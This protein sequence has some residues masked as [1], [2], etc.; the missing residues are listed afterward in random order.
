MGFHS[1]FHQFKLLQKCPYHQI[2]LQRECPSCKTTIPF[3]ISDSYT[4]SPFKCRCGEHLLDQT[5]EKSL[6]PNWRSVP[7]EQLISTD[8]K[9]WLNLNQEQVK[10]IKNIYVPLSLNLEKC[11]EYLNC[12][13]SVVKPDSFTMNNHRVV[14]SAPYIR[15]LSGKE[16]KEDAKLKAF[17]REYNFHDEI[18]NSSL[19]TVNSII[20]HVRK[21]I[22]HNHRICIER[23]RTSREGESVCP[24]ATAY[25]HWIR[26]IYGYEDD[27][28]VRWP[29]PYRK[30][31]T[32]LEFASK[33]DN[34]YLTELY[35]TLSHSEHDIRK[36]NRATIKWIF[37]RLLSHLTMNNFRCWLSVSPE[38]AK[39]NP[40]YRNIPYY[41]IIKSFYFSFYVLVIP[42]NK[43]EPLEFHWWN[44]NDSVQT[45]KIMNLKCP[46]Q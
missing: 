30:Y 27:F 34:Y 40:R 41:R 26:F 22:L 24:Y 7:L 29:T 42:E 11:P 38:L 15:H 5:L 28:F 6:D 19:K 21:T 44:D 18:Y 9:I 32:D 20:S 14:K 45:E 23:L 3:E 46:F 33:Q 36:E 35:N 13:L 43:N 1:I 37:N 16:E 31:P 25:D 4:Q 39:I 10:K 2:L 12:I 17:I 8:L